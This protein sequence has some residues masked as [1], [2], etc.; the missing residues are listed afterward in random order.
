MKIR[1]PL[2][3]A[4]LGT[5]FLVTATYRVDAAASQEG[6][7]SAP[8][9]LGIVG[10]HAA[11]LHTGKVLFY[12]GTE[13]ESAGSVA[14]VYDPAT[15]QVKRVSI[16]YEHP[17]F[18]SGVTVLR[19]GRVM[20]EGGQVDLQIGAGVKD[21][22]IFDPAT[23]TWSRG[24][25]TLKARYY[26]SVVELPDG[27]VLAVAGSDED[28]NDVPQL[29]VYDP[30]TATWTL[31]PPSANQ[32]SPTYPRLF[33]LRNGKIVRAGEQ[34][35]TRLFDPATNTWTNVG[36]MKYGNRVSGAAVL[37]PGLQKVLYSGGN[38]SLVATNTAEVFDAGAS[39]PG[40]KYT[41]AMNAGRTN[42]NLVLLADGTVLAVGGGRIAPYGTATKRAELYDPATGTW[43][44]MAAQRAQRTYHSTALLLPD[45]RV[46][47]AGSDF[48]TKA[49]TYEIFS[50]PYLFKGPR[51]SISSAPGS[52]AY[53]QSFSIGTTDSDISSVALIRPSAVTHGD[54]FDQ[55]YVDLSFSA[56]AAAVE[57]TAPASGAVAP[58]GY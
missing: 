7:W 21:V 25:P 35:Q 41:G 11:L 34:Q 9:D 18:C 40:W 5:T 14:R 20:V 24:T 44:L 48:G 15:N 57:A 8:R 1:R 49:E 23:E 3:A 17:A 43:K 28:V 16:P 45:G 6:S 10:V 55:R 33:L 26:P 29:E 47:S 30:A 58:P 51:P 37:L 22:S 52:I 27:R 19:D 31:L 32:V 36:R 4:A 12:S 54:N 56:G 50:P 38:N 53:G 46:I 42:H 2:L 39:T 13:G